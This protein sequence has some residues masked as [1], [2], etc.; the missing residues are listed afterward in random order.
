MAATN[1]PE[2]QAKIMLRIDELNRQLANLPATTTPPVVVVPPTKTDP[3][4]IP[5]AQQSAIIE[6]IIK[7]KNL[8]AA[9]N[10]PEEQAKIMLRIDELNRQLA[11]LPNPTTPP[12]V[13]VPPTNTDPSSGMDPQQAAIVEEIIKLKNLMATTN[14]PEEQAKVMAQIDALQKRLEALQT[15][16]PISTAIIPPSDSTQPTNLADTKPAPANILNIV[17]KTALQAGAKSSENTVN[18]SWNGGAGMQL[19]AS[20]SL[21]NPDWQDVPETNGKSNAEVAAPGSIL[22]FRVIQK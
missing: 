16:S 5:D 21:I 14:S 17:R 6:E 12:V 1:S 7:L 19:Q 3:N 15:G 20:K 18:L 8:M 22:F 10:S 11:S 13:V 2:E 4:S 9:A